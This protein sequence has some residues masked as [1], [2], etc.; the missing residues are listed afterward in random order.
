MSSANGS[1]FQGLRPLGDDR[2]G[3][4]GLGVLQA[5]ATDR[6]KTQTL[7]VD[8]NPMM[9][10]GLCAA[11]AQLDDL[12]IV[13]EASG[14]FA[15]MMACRQMKVD[16]AIIDVQIED[17]DVYEAVTSLKSQSPG[18]RV[19][20]SYVSLSAF[21][22]TQLLHV[23]V[24][25]LI[26]RNAGIS[27]FLQAVRTLMGGGSYLPGSI[28]SRL[29]REAPIQ[30]SLHSSGLSPR[31]LD[32]LRFVAAGYSNKEIARR[33]SLS[34]RTVETHRFNLRHKSGVSRLKDLVQL[35]ARLG[36]VAEPA[37]AGTSAPAPASRP[38]YEE[39]PA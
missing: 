11:L 38:R 29:F 1:P 8:P 35:A 32:V 24:N 14:G 5:L 17:V 2:A 36:L 25:G 7:V 28:A 39:T 6:P 3:G 20:I 26:P 23:G 18:L 13:A 16:L 37:P 30:T 9:R 12:K 19:L 33:L 31:E 15:A 34:V 10:A 27:E 22:V 21:E 4:A